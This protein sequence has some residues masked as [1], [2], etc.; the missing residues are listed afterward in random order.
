MDHLPDE[1]AGLSH[2]PIRRLKTIFREDA[3]K[4]IRTEWT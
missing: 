3:A 2:G 1:E 4:L